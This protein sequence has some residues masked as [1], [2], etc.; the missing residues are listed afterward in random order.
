MLVKPGDVVTVFEQRNKR[1]E[2]KTGVVKE[3]TE[4][5][6][7]IVRGAKVCIIKKGRK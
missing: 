1:G 6:D 5:K 3:L 7:K 2:W 4:G